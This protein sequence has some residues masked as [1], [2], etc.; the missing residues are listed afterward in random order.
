MKRNLLLTLLTL[1][2]LPAL[3]QQA[4]EAPAASEEAPSEEAAPSIDERVTNVEGKVTSI[5]EQQAELKAD[6]SF[7]KNLKFSGYVQARYLYTEPDAELGLLGESRFLIRR[8]RLKAV[9]TSELAQF[10]LQIDASTAGVELRDAEATLFIPGTRQ[11]LALTVGQMKWPFG[12]EAPQSSSD[13]E[14]PERTRVVR[15]FLPAERDLGA[16][17]AGRHGPLR[18]GVGVFNGNG[19]TYRATAGASFLPQDNDKSKDLVG[20]VGF[21]LG[22]V[23]GG[24]SGWYGLTLGK[25]PT[26]TYRRA[27]TRDRVGADLQVYG[28]LLPVGATALKAEYIAGKTYQR[29]GVEQLGVPAS[30]WYA[31]L[32]QNIGVNDAVA[33][34]YDHFDPSNGHGSQQVPTSTLNPVGTFGVTAVHYFGEYLKAS[35]TYELPVTDT[36]DHVEDPHD[37]SLTFQLQARF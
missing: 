21:D 14:F 22:W 19:T 23:S 25:G 6:T 5:E 8:S 15:A 31:L 30:G 17:V 36:V 27:Y 28:D 29:G 33:V 9:Y 24:V 37:N 10:V 11:N 20:R 16:R 3:A 34:R 12:F 18:F 32:V 2:S 26:D 13:R 7:L 1:T 35:L 4:D